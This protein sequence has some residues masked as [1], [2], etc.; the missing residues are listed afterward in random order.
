MQEE[1]FQLQQK[2]VIENSLRKILKPLQRKCQSKHQEIDDFYSTLENSQDVYAISNFS[3]RGTNFSIEEEYNPRIIQ[4]P[5]VNELPNF[6]QVQNLFNHTIQQ[7][8]EI[9]YVQSDLHQNEISNQ[10][11]LEL[12]QQNPKNVY[13]DMLEDLLADDY[14]L[15]EID[16]INYIQTFQSNIFENQKKASRDKKQTPKF[17]H[18]DLT[19]GIH[20]ISIKK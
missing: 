3:K 11:N 2:Q 15:I 14:K 16:D 1:T 5:L 10:H 19:K 8:P 4:N 18:Q 9:T 6:S 12:K 13:N 17:F 7:Q 20:K